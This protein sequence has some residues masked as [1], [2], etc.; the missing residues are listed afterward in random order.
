[1]YLIIGWSI[2]VLLSYSN[3]IP[4]VSGLP[5]DHIGSFA[6]ALIIAYAISRFNLL[7]VR[8]VMRRGLTL[9][10][11][12]ICLGGVYIGLI[13]LERNF[14]PSQP[15]YSIIG[16][17]TLLVLLLALLAQ[18]LRYGIQEWIDR[19]FYGETYSY[20]QALLR[21]DS[22]MGSI[23]DLK[24]LAD[25]MLP[26]I[27]KA[28]RVTDAKLIFEDVNSGDFTTQF[29][30]P[31]VEGTSNNELRLN[32]D[33]PIVTWLQKESNPL[34]LRQIDNT[35]EFKALWETEKERI[36]KSNV[37]LLCPIKSRGKLIGI[38]GL[39]KKRSNGL[40]TREDVELV[41]GLA[42]R[43]GI[44][45]ENARLYSQA[46]TWAHTDGLTKLYNHRY[47]N[48]R[49]EEEIARGSRFGTIFSLI[50][51]D[52]DFFKAYNDTYGHLA[53]DEVL[54]DIGGCIQT[55]IRSVDMSFRYGGEEFAA[56]LPETP[57][58]GAYLVAERIRKKIESKSSYGRMP[59]TASFGVA[60]WP[61][62][63]MMKEE[64]VASAD[65]ALYMAKQ[66]GRNRIC[67]SSDIMKPEVAPANIESVVNRSVISGVY[68]L[69]ATVDAK[70]RNT[71]DHS[72][73]VSQYAVAIAEAMNLPP[74][75]I[76]EIRNA[77]LLHDIGKIGIPN[78]ILNKDGILPSKNGSQLKLMLNWV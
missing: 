60:C 70:D 17:P 26:A 58:E 68:S 30:Y 27:S 73:K 59:V 28:I 23:I 55:S 56:I 52:I 5:L 21:F 29:T 72:K 16:F 77:G 66:T 61:T 19:L 14:F 12:V 49:L 63:G 43:A 1:M 31:E 37:E 57:L 6:N 42:T 50:M 15:V 32:L 10:L 40:Y 34:S 78:S 36:T 38:L 69:A 39:G 71:Y 44:A 35:P 33:S 54:V 7:D 22:K 9:L 64:V 76:A 41:M 65:A 48:E 13:L 3:L 46:V 4:A 18:R 67:L 2:L 24:Q 11:A 20:R 45:V 47:F 25:V 53:G 51:L 75:K 62:D 74:D 8:V